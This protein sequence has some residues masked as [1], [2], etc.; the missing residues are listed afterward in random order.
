MSTKFSIP[1]A[2]NWANLEINAIGSFLDL[3]SLFAQLNCITKTDE[4]IS[5]YDGRLMF[6]SHKLYLIAVTI[7]IPFLPNSQV[8]WV[9]DNGCECP[10]TLKTIVQVGHP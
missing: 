6:T 10:W 5:L 9:L 3:P 1:N 4:K 2:Y 8:Y 7:Y